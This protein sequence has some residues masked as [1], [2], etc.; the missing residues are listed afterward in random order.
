MN[1][2]AYWL[3]QIKVGKFHNTGYTHMENTQHHTH[4]LPSKYCDI[5]PLFSTLLCQLQTNSLR[6]TSDLKNK[7]NVNQYTQHYR[8]LC[9]I[10][11]FVN[12]FP[13]S[14]LLHAY[15]KPIH[16]SKIY[17]NTCILLY[18]IHAHFCAHTTEGGAY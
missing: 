18:S 1:S 12:W 16:I 14:V 5:W 3:H 10:I 9:F 11:M 2:I 15:Y 8:Q 4:N 13:G 6:T 7:L 17:T